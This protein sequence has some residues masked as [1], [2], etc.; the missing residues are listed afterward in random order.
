MER[1]GR[2]DSRRTCASPFAGCPYNL[3]HVRI[4]RWLKAGVPAAEIARRVHSP[5]VIHRRYQGCIDGHEQKANDKIA[6]AMEEDGDT[7]A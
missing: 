4:T 2:A 7:G 5:E 6:R 3:R 1:G